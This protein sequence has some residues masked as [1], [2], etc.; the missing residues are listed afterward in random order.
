MFYTS[1][2]RSDTNVTSAGCEVICRFVAH[3]ILVRLSCFQVTLSQ[4][5]QCKGCGLM[6]QSGYPRCPRCKMPQAKKG[7]RAATQLQGGTA[8]DSSGN[9]VTLIAAGALLAV[10]VMILV[11]K[12]GG[13]SEKPVPE[14]IDEAPATESVVRPATQTTPRPADGEVGFTGV[15]RETN[16]AEVRQ[17]ALNRLTESLGQKRLW[18]TVSADRGNDSLLIVVS[19]NC[20][21]PGMKPAIGAAAAGLREVGFQSLRCVEKH[22]ALVFEQ[23]L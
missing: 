12:G 13:D 1:I 19:A 18:A 10:V 9:R 6:V 15:V 11:A 17:E 7:G 23:G 4:E 21:E 20:K 14:A 3:R 22:G 5:Q 8:V 2:S 16:P